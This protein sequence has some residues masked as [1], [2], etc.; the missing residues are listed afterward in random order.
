MSEPLTLSVMRDELKGLHEKFTKELEGK[1]EALKSVGMANSSAIEKLN[2]AMNKKEKEIDELIAKLNRPAVATMDTPEGKRAFKKLLNEAMKKS[3][4]MVGGQAQVAPEYKAMAVGIDTAG[5]Y[6]VNEEYTNE[7]IKA[8]VQFSPVREYARAM[9][10]SG[11][12]VT[13]RKR[14][15]RPGVTK[16]VENNTNTENTNLAYGE[17][18]IPLKNYFSIQITPNQ[19]LEDAAFNVEEEISTDCSFEFGVSEG[20]DFIKGDGVTAPE[21]ILTN[22]NINSKTTGST[23]FSANDVIALYYNVYEAYAQRG[24][25]LFHRQNIMRIRQFVSDTGVYLWQPGLNGDAAATILGRPIREA[26][27]L[28]S[29]ANASDTIGIFGDLFRGYRIV[30]KVN[31]NML[32]DPYSLSS[33]YQTKYVLNK[34][35]G[36]AVVDENA[37]S[38]LVMH[39]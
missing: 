39:A 30:D 23:T 27:D 22:A 10:I 4:H 14:I 25:F 31:I 29:T 8:V 21:G 1:S 7:I 24:T 9:T 12:D 36:G 6:L 20:T 28:T 33:A 16:Q 35:T 15:A 3:F 17:V 26:V 34:R 19:L 2:E 38:K 5:G 13:L 18:K 11:S 37:I 32:R